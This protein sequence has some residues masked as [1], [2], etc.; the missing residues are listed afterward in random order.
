[1]AATW[2]RKT[3]ICNKKA[4]AM[5]ITTKIIGKYFLPQPSCPAFYFCLSY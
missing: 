3:L 5:L 4:I 2:T 1:M